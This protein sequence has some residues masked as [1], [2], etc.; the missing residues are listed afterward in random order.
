MTKL[1]SQ[2]TIIA[3]SYIMQIKNFKKGYIQRISK[4]PAGTR[5]AAKHYP[6][7]WITFGAGPRN[8]IGMHFALVEIKILRVRLLKKYT[9]T[10]C[11]NRNHQP[12]ERF[13]GS[14]VITSKELII[15]L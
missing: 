13:K 9:F 2:L 12:Y 10:G 1:S 14:F 3:K 6:M 5:I 7:E 15:Q 8:C 4:I 11:D